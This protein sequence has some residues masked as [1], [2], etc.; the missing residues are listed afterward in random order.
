MKKY[1]V[2]LFAIP[3][4]LNAQYDFDA[5]ILGSVGYAQG[6][7]G[8]AATWIKN[9]KDDLKANF[10]Y[11]RNGLIDYSNIDGDVQAV[12]KNPNKSAGKVSIL[13]EHLWYLGNTPAAY[14]PQNSI[15]KIAYSMIESSR[16]PKEWVTILN[17]Q[18]DAVVIP[19]PFLVK[20]YQ[21]SG[22]KIPIF[23]LPCG[24]H[25]DEF[26]N[27]S[28]VSH[29]EFIFGMSAG[30][31]ARKNH[32]M[33]IEAFIQEFRRDNNV[34][35][36]IHGRFGDPHLK[37]AIIEKIKK[38]RPGK[39]ELT[40]E[41]FTRKDY[42]QFYANLDCYVFISKGE[43]FSISPREAMALGIPCILTNNTAHTTLC[44]TQLVYSIPAP[45]VEP[46]VYP[47]FGQVCGHY[48]NCRIKDVRLALR[49]VYNNYA[50]FTERASALREWV[51]QYDYKQMKKKYIT[52][53][54]PKK[55]ILG[56]YNI[57]EDEYLMTNSP[58]LYA[59][60]QKVIN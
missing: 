1:L 56:E 45:Y 51:K 21:D 36:K 49:N 41:T 30:F 47:I 10:I 54:K 58:A 27:A 4:I 46:A 13:F 35:L 53:L 39:I 15:V 32:A 17:Q 12:M 5:T 33:L 43:G 34:K 6:I 7:D 2:L 57:I 48:L 28:K 60:Y 11:T 42:V 44:N 26:Y 14:V 23:I 52:L 9:I 25:L 31:E 50:V 18:F 40:S 55:V 8:F 24:I 29:K 38:I 16:I 59:K 19:D 3:S 20:V 37:H 22:V